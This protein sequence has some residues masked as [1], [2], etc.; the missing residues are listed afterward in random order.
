VDTKKVY[1]FSSATQNTARFVQKLGYPALDVRHAEHTKGEPFVL[2][3][4]TYADG[5]G[6]GALPRAVRA[7]I[8]TNHEDI[9]GVIGTGNR[10]FGETFCL[11]AKMVARKCN[12]P[13]LHCVE[14]D[15]N[16]DDVTKT[17]ERIEALD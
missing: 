7:F 10:N 13:L 17:R 14:L 12:V 8:N 2:V 15:G 16:D 9:V 4:P 11:G 6:R 5:E 1:Y 3:C